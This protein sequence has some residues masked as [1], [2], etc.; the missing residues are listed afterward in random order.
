M[1]HFQRWDTDLYR[2][3]KSDVDV[4]EVSE[5]GLDE[6]WDNPTSRR[7]IVDTIVSNLDLKDAVSVLEDKLDDDVYKQVVLALATSALER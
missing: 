3:V 5:V 2:Y 6:M 4:N 7:E 1:K